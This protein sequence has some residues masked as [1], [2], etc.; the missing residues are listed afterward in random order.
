[1]VNKQTVDEQANRKTTTNLT[2]AQEF[3][4]ELWEEHVRHEFDTHNTE[5]T[6]ATMVVEIEADRDPKL[7]LSTVSGS[8][9]ISR[10]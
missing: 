10:L 2:S 5:D 9:A 7:N 3:L 1:M 8:L 4:Q 6:L